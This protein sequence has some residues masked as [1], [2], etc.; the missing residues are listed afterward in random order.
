MITR[1]LK[2]YN[3]QVI[4]GIIIFIL[5]SFLMIDYSI[6]YH[7]KKYYPPPGIGELVKEQ[8]MASQYPKL[9]IIKI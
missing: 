9:V 2:N 8:A 5:I 1:F 6:D 7:T 3:I 4:I